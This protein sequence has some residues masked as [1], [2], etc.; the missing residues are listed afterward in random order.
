MKRRL[1]ILLVAALTFMVGALGDAVAQ[2][3]PGPNR[4]QCRYE[5]GRTDELINQAREAVQNSGSAIG[6]Q[7]LEQAEKLQNGAY[8][9]FEGQAYVMALSLTRKSRE[10]ASLA[11]SNS[12]MAEQLEGVVQGRMERAR[13]MLDR[14]RDE[15]P[16]PP[17]PAMVS[18]MEQAQNYL[19]QAWEFYR[20]R[21]F[22]AA[23]KLVEQVEQAARRL[24]NMAQLGQQA[25]QMFQQRLENA[26]RVM[27]YA[28]ELL[29]EC[30]SETG[31]Q[32]LEQAERA[33]ETAREFHQQQQ[34]RAAFA[35]LGQARETARRAARECRDGNHL[36]ERYIRLRGE[37]DRARQRLGESRPD[38]NVGAAVSGLLNQAR[39]QLELARRNLSDGQVES[40]QIA[41][42]AAQMALRQAQ[43]HL[44]GER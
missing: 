34:Y 22:R 5:L 9:A 4:E 15:W 39:E 44:G 2:T 16:T 35:A 8:R 23:A 41:L 25:G 29:A 30:E 38:E 33:L 7:A 21:Q 11:L 10:Q 18:L 17:E 1:I 12:R 6:A 13:E 31:R 26:E 42:Q 3:G 14:I 36:E 32:Q 19:A 20:Q 37:L 27:E 43:R 24:R 28:R 40:A